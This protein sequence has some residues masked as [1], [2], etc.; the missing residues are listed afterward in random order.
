MKN[1]KRRRMFE[2]YQ[3]I[4]LHLTGSR[5]KQIAHIIGRCEDTVSAYIQSYQNHGVAG[6][7][8]RAST[9]AP[10]RL[11]QEQHEQLKQTIVTKLPYEVGFTAKHNWT[12]QLVSEY[13]KREYGP[14]YT[15]KGTSKVLHRLN[16][17]YT[18]PT[19]TLAAADKA[20]QQAFQDDTFP[21]LKKD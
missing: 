8:M 19:Y 18:K 3:T 14:I 2:R 7:Q 21:E 16:L 10:P 11:T 5:V 13:I 17:S 20:K 12:L 15:L 4:H 6:L 1:E 9:G